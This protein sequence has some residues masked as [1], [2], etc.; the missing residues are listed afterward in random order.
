[1]VT[2][3]CREKYANYSAILPGEKRGGKEEEG[4]IE[5]GRNRRGKGEVGRSGRVGNREGKV[6]EE[7][8]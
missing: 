8:D 1:M 3:C 6:K 7:E 2:P 5:E 4:S